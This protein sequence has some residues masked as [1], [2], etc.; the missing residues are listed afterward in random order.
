[1]AADLI[2]RRTLE[3]PYNGLHVEGEEGAPRYLGNAWAEMVRE[4]PSSK[5]NTH[6]NAP[7]PACR[8]E[9]EIKE[10]NHRKQYTQIGIS[11][12]VLLAGPHKSVGLLGRVHHTERTLHPACI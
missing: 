12:L 2:K 11:H 3:K 6:T 7:V 1:M 10:K 9:M 8:C 4:L 5:R